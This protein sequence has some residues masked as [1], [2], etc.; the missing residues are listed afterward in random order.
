MSRKINAIT[1]H[2]EIHTGIIPSKGPIHKLSSFDSRC[3]TVELSGEVSGFDDLWKRIMEQTISFYLLFNQSGWF[4]CSFKLILY[5]L[6]VCNVS[7]KEQITL[8]YTS[9][10]LNKYILCNNYF[11]N[12]VS[13]DENVLIFLSDN[14]NLG[15]SLSCKNRW[16]FLFTLSYIFISSPLQV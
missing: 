8:Y 10:T 7:W 15:T 9:N 5:A 4:F 1:R 3:C 2:P 11:S 6:F 12:V 14:I 13:K 16:V